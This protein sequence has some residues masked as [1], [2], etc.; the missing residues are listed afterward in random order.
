[1]KPKIIVRDERGEVEDPFLVPVPCPY[2]PYHQSEHLSET[3]RARLLD[4]T[5]VLWNVLD[6]LQI[7]PTVAYR[8]KYTLNAMTFEDLYSIALKQKQYDATALIRN[9][10]DA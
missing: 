10:L 9:I 1:M 7:S 2:A 5:S 3:D 8:R 6:L 4:K